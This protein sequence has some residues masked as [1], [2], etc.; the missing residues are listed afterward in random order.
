[1]MLL[2]GRLVAAQEVKYEVKDSFVDRQLELYFTVWNCVKRFSELVFAIVAS[3]TRAMYWFLDLIHLRGVTAVLDLVCLAFGLALAGVMVYGICRLLI[4]IYAFY[5]DLC[6]KIIDLW[7]AVF[8]R[9]EIKT[10][11]S[12]LVFIKKFVKDDM[13]YYEFME[14]GKRRVLRNVDFLVEAMEIEVN[15]MSIA[16]S[17][18]FPSINRSIGAV[19]TASESNELRVE[20]CFWRLDDYLVT[21]GHVANMIATSTGRCYLS[22]TKEDKK[23]LCRINSSSVYLANDN[24]EMEKNLFGRADM[25]VFAIKLT[26]K[27]WAALKMTKASTKKSSNYDQTVSAVGFVDNLLMTSAGKTLQDSGLFKLHHT[28]STN[29]G[30][31]GSPLYSGNSVIGMH[32]AGQL[33]HNVAIRIEAILAYLHREES[34]QYTVEKY[35]RHFKHGG[36]HVSIEDTGDDFAIL[37]Y[38]TGEAVL[39]LSRREILEVDPNYFIALDIHSHKSAKGNDR[40]GL[41]D[42]DDEYECANQVAYKEL[43]PER[44]THCNSSPKAQDEVTSYLMSQIDELRTLGFDPEKYQ[45]PTIDASTEE[46]SLRNHLQLFGDRNKKVFL[47]PTSE[48]SGRVAMLVLNMLQDNRFT[49]DKDYKSVDYIVDVLDSSL[50]KEQKSPGYPYQADGLATNG[51][52]LKHFTK[53]GF[54]EVVQREWNQKFQLKIFGKGEPTKVAKLDAGMMRII[55][56][57]PLHKT[58]KHQ[59]LFKNLLNAAMENWTTSPVKY[60]FSPGNPGNIENLVKTLGLGKVFGSDK[61]NWDYMFFSW[62]FDICEEIVVGLLVQSNDTTD[63]E[64]A[65]I[66]EDIRQAFR[67]VATDCQYRCTNGKVFQSA[68]DGIMKTGWFLTIFINSVAQLVVDVMAKV[69]MGQTDSQIQSPQMAIIVGGDDVLQKFSVE[70]NLDHYMAAAMQVGIKMEPFEVHDSMNGVEFFSN[71]LLVRDGVWIFL[72]QRFTKHIAHLATS[73]RSELAGSLNSHMTNHCWDGKKYNFFKKMFMHFRENHPEDFPLKFLQPVMLL[74]YKS[75]GYE[76][77]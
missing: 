19:M 34:N 75:K 56:G 11:V 39:G 49:V 4:Q 10:G 44:P 9:W 33:K 13:I 65:I 5:K 73:K 8:P 59:V 37:N 2:S 14:D 54:A 22:S 71:E 60:G 16:G 7:H 74:R 52:V 3:L 35:A 18:L 77:A 46:K 62:I 48:E 32:V 51:A 63:E 67:E 12:G 26:P 70:F 24:F 27:M 21:A 30:F 58:V 43:E 66:V 55:M 69:R 41:A 15:E 61:K 64:H 1:M 45:Y 23:G 47:P 6:M 25:D 72:P 36:K 57:F 76:S 42:Y 28:A 40:W 20:G 31:S 53:R 38:K 17:T 50:V 29:K 68:Y